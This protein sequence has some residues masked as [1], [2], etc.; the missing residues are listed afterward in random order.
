MR[1]LQYEK[2]RQ[3][4]GGDLFFLFYTSFFTELRITI[5]V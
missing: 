1:I 3:I 5:L 2:V 4:S